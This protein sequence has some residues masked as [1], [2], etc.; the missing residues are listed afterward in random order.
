MGCSANPVDDNG[1][2]TNIG[3]IDIRE[4]ELQGHEYFYV[5]KS[6][7]QVGYFGIT[8]KANCKYHNIVHDDSITR[9]QRI[10]DAIDSL[11]IELIK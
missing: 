11:T 7:G 5:K 8:H 1:I 4:I 6:T 2:V 9:V 3:N 10:N